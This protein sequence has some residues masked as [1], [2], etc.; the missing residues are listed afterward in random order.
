MVGL[1]L[2]GDLVE[3]DGRFGALRPRQIGDQLE[4]VADDVRL[5]ALAVHALE[6]AE[7]AIDDLLRV[8][9][10]LRVV[11]TLA[12]RTR[13]R[14]A[15]A[16]AELALDGAHLLAEDVLALVLAELLLHL[17]LDLGADLRLWP[18]PRRCA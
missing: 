1:E 10:E 9:G 5:R 7:L 13:A 12:E 6:T 4:V 8:F 14:L 16:V 11:E 17:G 15:V 18:W 3:V 2:R